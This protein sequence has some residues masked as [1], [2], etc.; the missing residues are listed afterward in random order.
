[1][2]NT[3]KRTGPVVADL[4]RRVKTIEEAPPPVAVPGPQGEP[5]PKGDPG[6][7]GTAGR[8]KRVEHHTGTVSGSQGVAIV[9]FAPPFAVPPLCTVID[10][11]EGTQQITGA[12]TA[13]TTTSATGSV[14]RSRGTLALSAGPFETAPAGTTVKVQAIGD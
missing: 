13:T 9:T 10:G 7:A 4:S 1:M 5:G 11:W 12:V 6:T 2:S 3:P 14:R 8:P